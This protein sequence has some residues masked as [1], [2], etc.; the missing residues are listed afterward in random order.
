LAN[1]L[2]TYTAPK[3]KQKA[4]QIF[5]IWRAPGMPSPTGQVQLPRP[6]GW[7][8]ALGAAA[9]IARACMTNAG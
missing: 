8:L 1:N 5:Q 6:F 4:R 7:L 2:I 3:A 9:I